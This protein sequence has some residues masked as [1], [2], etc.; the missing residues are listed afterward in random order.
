[1]EFLYLHKPQST[2]DS[3]HTDHGESHASLQPSRFSTSS[4]HVAS[5]HTAISIE[6]RPHVHPQLKLP[7]NLKSLT[8]VAFQPLRVV[9]RVLGSLELL[10]LTLIGIQPGLSGHYAA[11]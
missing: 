2:N 3:Q 5:S 10:N 9:K 11:S 8:E 1:M 7:S 6:T 4:C